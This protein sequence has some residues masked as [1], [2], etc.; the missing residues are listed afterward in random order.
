MWN[1]I[2]FAE[3]QSFQKKYY[4]EN[5]TITSQ[6]DAHSDFPN[7][8]VC[9]NGGVPQR[10]ANSNVA[11]KRHHQ[12]DPRLRDE[13]GV[14]EEELSDAAI[15]GDLPSVE[16]EDGQGLGNCGCGE[17]DVCPCQHAEKEVHGSMETGPCEDDEDEQ[18]VPKKGSD[19]GNEEGDGNPHVLVLQAGD[20]QQME[21]CVTNIR[22][23]YSTH[24]DTDDLSQKNE[25]SYCV[26]RYFLMIPESHS[27]S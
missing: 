27:T 19:I 14:D 24:I 15:Q 1:N 12:Q 4:R 5:C 6:K 22:M 11:V 13:S 25:S 17:H 26:Q 21:D 9:E 8:G 23:V 7:Q 18:A 20:A 2:I 16:P 10:V 3:S